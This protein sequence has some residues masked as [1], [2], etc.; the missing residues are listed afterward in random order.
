L[1]ARTVSTAPHNGAN[2]G[3]EGGGIGRLA[4]SV[5]DLPPIRWF[6]RHQGAQTLAETARPTP[7]RPTQP[8]FAGGEKRPAETSDAQN[9][10]TPSSG[11]EAWAYKRRGMRPARY[12]NRPPSV[13]RRIARAIPIGSSAREIAEAQST[14]S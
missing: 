1:R 4:R 2:F 14:P 13:P 8:Q 12:A 11:V 3:I 9:S 5:A 6:F 10:G 7:R